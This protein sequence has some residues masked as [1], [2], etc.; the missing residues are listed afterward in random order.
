M[1]KGFL[2]ET[3]ARYGYKGVLVAVAVLVGL[4]LLVAQVSGYEVSS[5]VDW[6]WEQ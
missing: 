6:A 1:I 4:V 3:F 5:I 2:S